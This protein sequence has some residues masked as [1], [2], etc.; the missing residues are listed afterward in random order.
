MGYDHHQKDI[1]DELFVNELTRLT[2][3]EVCAQSLWSRILRRLTRDDTF[4]NQYIG[5][6]SYSYRFVPSFE[7]MMSVHLRWCRW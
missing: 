6:I 3:E 1:V 7:G 4:S 2:Y 5:D